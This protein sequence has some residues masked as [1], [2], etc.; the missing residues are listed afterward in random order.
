MLLFWITLIVEAVV[1]VISAIVYA[2]KKEWFSLFILIA[3]LLVIFCTYFT[4]YENYPWTKKIFCFAQIEYSA[5][6]Y[7]EG[8]YY[9][10][11]ENE[12]P[13]GFGRLTYKHF[14]DEKFYAIID[15]TGVHKALYYEGELEHGWRVGQGMVLYDGGY[16]DIGTFYGKWELGKTV[17]E[18]VRWKDDKYYVNLKIVAKDA[19]SADDIYETDYWLTE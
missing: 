3:D 15:S 9:G 11:W 13:Q 12:Y 7:N 14:V 1:L 16:K 2:K 4:E 17:F 10:G 8:N 6:G 5:N 19:I 18:G